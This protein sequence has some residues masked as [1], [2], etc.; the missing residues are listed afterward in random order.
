MYADHGST[1]I[2]T[3]FP[4][5]CERSYANPNARH[6][7]GRSA[8]ASLE[9]ALRRTAAALGVAAGVPGPLDQHLVLTSGGTEG[10]N[11]VVR[12]SAWRF[13]VTAPTEHHATLWAAQQHA[14]ASAG[15]CRLILLPVARGSGRVD[16]AALAETLRN[17][18]DEGPGL[19]SI[20]HVNNEIGTVQDLG[21][22]A[23]VVSEANRRRSDGQRVWFHTDAV[24]SP[25]HVALPSPDAVDF[26][27]LSA[28]KFS[29]PPGFGLLYC[30]VA[31]SLRTPILYGGAPQAGLRPGTV[32]VGGA[33]ALADAL[34]DATDVRT[35]PARA[36][37]LAALSAA[38]RRSLYDLAAA[39]LVLLTG[40]AEDRDRA[41]HVVS[42]CVRGAHRR[43]LVA[44]LEREGPVYASGGSAC[45][46][47]AGVPSHVL[48]ATGVP[49]EFVHGSLRLTFA[50]T[51]TMDEV[52][53]VLIPALRRVVLAHAVVSGGS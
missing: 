15:R 11:L 27:T 22:L 25:G 40:P 16:P 50:H 7:P 49:A 41:P 42:L 20:M 24:Q 14:I 53:G 31:G 13:I 33:V 4:V 8:R 3:R 12:Q 21:A 26:L 6:C 30:R 47:E 46:T 45:S 38:V 18:D 51:N 36:A 39:G 5:A 1:S 2:P 28:H 10:N 9:G 35:L 34:T 44:A 52:E 32:A 48:V 43:D 29:G 19:V 37:H 17:V 23:A